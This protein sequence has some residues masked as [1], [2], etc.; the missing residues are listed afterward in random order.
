MPSP[1]PAPNLALNPS[2]WHRSQ[3]QMFLALV[4]LVTLASAVALA[5][6][7]PA[8]DPLDIWALPGMSA[9]LIVLQGL[10]VL[11]RITLSAA[12]QTAYLGGA[13]YVLLALSHQY[14]VMPAT[15]V[16]LMENT[17][18]FAVIYAAAFLTFPSRLATVVT[19]GILILATA[20]CAWHVTMTV[21]D[22]MRLKLAAASAQFLLT[23]AVLIVL[24]RTIGVQHHRLMATRTA[25][26]TDVL[27]GLANRRAAEEHLAALAQGDTA[28]TLVLFDLDHFKSVNDTYG[29]ATGD[30]V[31]RGVAGAIRHLPPGSVA[32]RWGGE[33]FLL[34]LPRHDRAEIRARLDS[35]RTQLRGLVLGPVS[36]VTA[37]FGVASSR[38]GEHPDQ[39]LARADTAMYAAK[40]QGR[41]DV[42]VAD[43][44]FRHDLPDPVN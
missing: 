23:G 19:S 16:T 39:V 30:A 37:S 15:S 2:E 6:Q 44:I 21:P 13:T 32:S 35:L 22:D 14:E 20:I 27:T 5:L 17:Y 9:L 8:F 26:Y 40:A 25:A 28:F 11:K 43:T 3:R 41:N 4:I 36:G 34:I 42:R 33:E 18:W 31:L 12:L 24:N 38:A 1:S 10:L 7:R 29:H